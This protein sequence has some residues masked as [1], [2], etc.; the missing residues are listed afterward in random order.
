MIEN[1]QFYIDERWV[2]PATPH[3]FAVI[4]PA[5]EEQCAVISLGDAA[6]TDAAV[7]AARAAFEGWSRTAPAERREL[8][9]NVLTVYKKRSEDMSQAISLEMGAPIDLARNSQTPSGTWHIEGFLRAFDEI[10]WESVR[11][12]K[13][14]ERIHRD[15]IGV[16]GMI[17]PWNWPMNQVSLKVIPAL[18]AGCTMVLKPSEVAPLSSVVWTEIMD[19]AGCPAG[20]FNMVNGD[21]PGVGTQ[22]SSHMDVDMI[23]FTGS[24]RAGRAITAASVF[25]LKRVSLELGG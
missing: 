14:G 11:D 17:T 20:V 9:E 8:I 23:S 15:P 22:L 10:T 3:D 4:D 13:G 1:R 21:G 2:D 24:T 5:T 16:V 7:A 25:N 19:E 18:A 6:D 12:E